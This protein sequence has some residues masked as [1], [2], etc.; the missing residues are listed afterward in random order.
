[1]Q[2]TLIDLYCF[3]IAIAAILGVVRFSRIYPGFKP[4]VYVCWAALL[5]ETVCYFL[6]Y[7]RGNTYIPYGIY[8]L[9]ES[10]LI[11]WFFRE[12]GIFRKKPQLFMAL[13]YFYIAAWITEAVFFN[14]FGK[15]MTWFRLV[16]AFIVVLLSIVLI[17]K[18]L[19]IQRTF[20]LKSSVFLICIAF[21]LY[22]TLAVIAGVFELYDFGGDLAL[23]IKMQGIMMYTNVI[24]N[25]IYALAVLWIPQRL[26]YSLPY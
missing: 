17:S 2:F 4:F 22:F 16:H 1:M 24:V 26:R 5:T 13:I 6:V 14:A 20:L 12:M 10:L 7:N 9:A 23:R 21:L 25:L 18:E 11:T 3:S 8:S 15:N 19:S